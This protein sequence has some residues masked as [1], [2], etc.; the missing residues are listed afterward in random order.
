MQ[1]SAESEELAT[2]PRRS[3]LAHVASTVDIQTAL[4]ESGID[5]TVDGKM[6]PQTK[7][8]LRSFQ[9]KNKLKVT[10]IADS[11]TLS[12]LGL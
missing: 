8:A 3:N 11:P 10:G 9:Q 12:K 7:S 4:A 6:G 1:P 2:D 5:I